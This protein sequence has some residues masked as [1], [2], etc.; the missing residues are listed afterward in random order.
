MTVE[1]VRELRQYILDKTGAAEELGS[2]D[3][4]EAQDL[5]NLI[6]DVTLEAQ[7]ERGTP[8]GATSMRYSRDSGNF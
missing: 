6:M 3:Q 7:K 4:V 5:L 1:S 2:Q 8:A